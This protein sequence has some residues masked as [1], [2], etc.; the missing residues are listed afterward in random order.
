MVLKT[1][2][3]WP[4][5]LFVGPL[6][7]SKV[8]RGAYIAKTLEDDTNSGVFFDLC[9]QAGGPRLLPSKPRGNRNERSSESQGPMASFTKVSNED[10]DQ[11]EFDASEREGQVCVKTI[12]HV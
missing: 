6:P 7:P 11:A 2:I 12:L 4:Q 3:S 1:T 9:R 8:E 5:F 10:V